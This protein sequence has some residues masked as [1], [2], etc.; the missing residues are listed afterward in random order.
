MKKVFILSVLNKSQMVAEKLLYS[1]QRS[2]KARGSSLLTAVTPMEKARSPGVDR[3]LVSLVP[4][5]WK[6]SQWGE[7]TGTQWE[8]VTLPQ[9]SSSTCR[10]KNDSEHR[11][12]RANWTWGKE[13]KPHYKTYDNQR[14]C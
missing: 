11:Y 4:A 2:Y 7:M 3:R 13:N 8:G 5:L 1:Q 14:L 9:D 10:P 6:E 12:C